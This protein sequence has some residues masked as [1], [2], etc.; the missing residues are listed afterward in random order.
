[1]SDIEEESYVTVDS[2]IKSISIKELEE[3]IAKAIAEATKCSKLT[4]HISH[5]EAK[6][7]IHN[8]VEL[9]LSLS[10]DLGKSFFE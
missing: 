2:A 9:N 8:S 3:C 7:M 1:M 5:I 6:G 10:N 4:C